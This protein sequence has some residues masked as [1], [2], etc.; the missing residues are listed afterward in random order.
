[1]GFGTFVVLDKHLSVEPIDDQYQNRKDR[2]ALIAPGNITLILLASE[3]C[4]RH[5][6]WH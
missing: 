1:M 2:K 6:V 3:N 5:Q 4:K